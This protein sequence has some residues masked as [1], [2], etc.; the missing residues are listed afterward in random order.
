MKMGRGGE[1]VAGGAGGAGR[2]QRA[3]HHTH[4]RTARA[5]A[6]ARAAGSSC[7]RNVMWAMPRPPGSLA[8]RLSSAAITPDRR[9]DGAA[10]EGNAK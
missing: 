8:S 1:R 5:A 9:A 3:H 7:P 6:N 10:M 4:T 2:C